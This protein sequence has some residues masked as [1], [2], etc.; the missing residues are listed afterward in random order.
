[1]SKYFSLRSIPIN[2]RFCFM[3]ATPVVPLPM[4]GSN[5]MSPLDV[6]LAARG[7]FVRRI[8][9][10]TIHGCQ[11]WVLGQSEIVLKNPR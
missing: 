8:G 4:N 2:L 5:T 11:C 3:A 6:L 10:D 1:M 7:K 9:H